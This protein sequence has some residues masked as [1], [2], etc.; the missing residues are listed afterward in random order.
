FIT[1]SLSV[2]APLT[3]SYYDSICSGNTYNFNG[4][5]L[6]TAGNYND[7]VL[8]G[9]GCD[10]I[11]TLHLQIKQHVTS[12]TNGAICQGASYRFNGTSYSTS[13]NYSVTLP[14]SNGCDSIAT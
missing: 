1:L 4:T 13:G 14:G 8:T 5:V 3:H 10:S 6:T 7:T 12:N 2:R 11:V 9:A